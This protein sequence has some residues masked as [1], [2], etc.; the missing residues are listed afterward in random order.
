[1]HGRQAE[2]QGLDSKESSYLISPRRKEV[3]L[4]EEMQQQHLHP[5]LCA[6]QLMHHQQCQAKTQID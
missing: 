6:V 5:R 1:M 3:N 2:V 4:R